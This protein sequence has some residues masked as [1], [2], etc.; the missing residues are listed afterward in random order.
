M[1]KRLREPAAA[2]LLV[3]L[4]AGCAGR[5]VAAP[6]PEKGSPVVYV[7]PLSELRLDRAAAVLPFQV[8]AGVDGAVGEQVAL[9]F[10]D[11]LMGRQAFASVQVLPARYV[12]LAEAVAAGRSAGVDYV[13]AGRVNYL[14]EGYELGGSAVDVSLRLLSTGSG[15]TVWYI[16]QVI[17]QP[18]ASPDRSLS[19]EFRDAFSWSY[20][21]RSQVTAPAVP[22]MLVRIAEDMTSVM[23]GSRTV[24]R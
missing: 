19:R 14:I 3:A 1:R 8:P 4:L 15:D 23:A 13:V 2:L 20:P 16:G 11:V 7:H 12:S 10:K 6:P 24:P 9:L 17:R 22:N 18:Q 5:E 21:S